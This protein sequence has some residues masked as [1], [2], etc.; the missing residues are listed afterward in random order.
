MTPTISKNITIILNWS[1][2]RESNPGG[3][4][5]NEVSYHYIIPAKVWSGIGGSNSDVLSELGWKPSTH[6]QYAL[7]RIK[8]WRNAEVTL[9]TPFSAFRFRGEAGASPVD[10]PNMEESW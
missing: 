9:P 8:F 5:G 4:I 1:G 3:L 6:N 10:I 2:Y 7:S